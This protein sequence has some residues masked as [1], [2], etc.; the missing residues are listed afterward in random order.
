MKTKIYKLTIAVIAVMGFMIQSCADLNVTNLTEPDSARA[1]A[2]PEDLKG[3][4]G[5][6]LKVAH[7]AAQDYD[8]PAMAMDV[9]ADHS[10]CSWGNSAMRDLSSEPRKGFNN[11]LTYPYFPVI[12]APW[13]SWYSAISSVNDVLKAIE[14]D[15]VKIGPDGADN[16][17]VLAWCYFV[18][19]V[20]HEYLGLTFDKANV[21]FWDSD[22]STLTLQPWQDL[23]DAS[24]TL[25]DKAIEIADA[26][27]FV[28][29]T[30]WVAGQ[31]IT[32]V[33]LSR[34]ANSFAARALVYGSRNKAH[35]DAVDWTKVL[36]YTNKGIQQDFAPE[37]GDKYNWNDTY[38]AQL[39]YS[40]WG[41]VDNRIVNILDHSKPSRWADGNT[42]GYGIATSTDH[43]LVTD[44]EYLSQQAFNPTR[45]YYHFS[46]YRH[47]RY[48]YVT[49]SVWYGDKP[50]P[51]FLAWENELMKAEA[52]LRKGDVPGA[53]AILNSPTGARKVRGQLPDVTSTVA[54]DVLRI[55]LDERDIELFFTGMGIS[56]F[57]MRRTDRLLTGTILHFPVPATELEITNV[58]V[59][60]ISGSPDGINISNGSWTGYTK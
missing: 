29:P 58:P 1:L 20:T 14:K 34:L 54:A 53:V 55:I 39:T 10:T 17:M 40:G 57:D 37:I 24:I 42:A 56:Y 21:I 32:N 9:M 22:L 36:N 48:A 12:R 5:G 51:T 60:T 28:I 16:P 49:A 2:N 44:F 35:N 41:R 19:G 8:G 38:F 30:T 43:R 27:E 59:Y 11:S 45:G 23:I 52:K 15:G 4:A 3:L 18:S 26:N 6:A 25:F 50:K 7:T 46:S 33:E 31:T 13:E 47:V